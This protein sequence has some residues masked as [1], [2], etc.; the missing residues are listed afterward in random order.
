MKKSGFSGIIEKTFLETVSKFNLIRPQEKIL[1]ALSGGPDSVLLAHL[2]NKFK[3]QFKITPV[4]MHI[5]HHLRGRES[6]KDEK[7]ACEYAGKLGLEFVLKDI[8]VLSYAENNKLSLEAAGRALRY[9][10]FE[11]AMK[12]KD[13]RKLATAHHLDDLAETMV[14]R[15][16]KGSGVSGLAAIPVKRGDIIRPLLYLEKHDILA[17][18]DQHHIK[19]RI[20]SSNKNDAFD[21]NYI[22]NSII[23]LFEKRFPA[24][25]R[26][27]MDLYEIIME[28]EQVWQALLEPLKKSIYEEEG[29]VSIKK[30]LLLR[31]KNTPKALLRRFL[32]WV[33]QNYMAGD[34]Y[35]NSDLLDNILK[36]CENKEGNK[37]VFKNNAFRIVSSYDSIVFE[38]SSKKFPKKPKYVKLNNNLSVPYGSYSLIIKRSAGGFRPEGPAKNACSFDPG[39]MSGLKVRQRLEGDRIRIAAARTKK[40]KDFFIDCKF[41]VIQREESFLLEAADEKIIAVYIP[42]YGF[43]V[44]TDFYVNKKTK[45]IISVRVLKKRG[46]FDA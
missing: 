14:F 21:R 8:D 44:S 40:V 33:I 26:K 38:K 25:R 37:T 32:K 7:F 19:Y 24:F 23:P 9:Q 20:D 46:A 5:N 35:P 4:L 12:E 30:N 41:S 3:E 6:Q 11:D 22:R 43:R 36:F 29:L 13:C 34:F 45:E 42:G 15:L 18:L 1:I 10:A 2:F 17:Y 39:G 28:E 27:F 31:N 16:L